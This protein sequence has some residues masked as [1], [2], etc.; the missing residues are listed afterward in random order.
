MK[1][2]FPDEDMDAEGGGR[3]DAE[4]PPQPQTAEGGDVKPD[5]ASVS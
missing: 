3:E 2:L 5:T 1:P 4:E